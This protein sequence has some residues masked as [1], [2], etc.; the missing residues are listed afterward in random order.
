MA[1]FQWP[2]KLL[3]AVLMGSKYLPYW[4]HHFTS[5]TS[6]DASQAVSGRQ[7]FRVSAV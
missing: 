2:M 1:A 7:D 5:K 3:A 4:I 6:S